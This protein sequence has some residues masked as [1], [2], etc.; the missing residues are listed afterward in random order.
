M[1][2]WKNEDRWV[3]ACAYVCMRV[4]VCMCVCV[5][6]CVHECM[7]VHNTAYLWRSEENSLQELVFSST[8]CVPGLS[9]GHRAW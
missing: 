7:H 9:L 4:C 5:C 8:L 6:V 2:A 1:G 3:C